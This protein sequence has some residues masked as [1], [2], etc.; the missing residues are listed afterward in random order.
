MWLRKWLIFLLLLPFGSVQAHNYQAR[1]DVAEW[2][3]EPGPMSCRL[4][5]SVP[6]YG[7]AVFETKAGQRQSFYVETYRPVLHEG[8]ARVTIKAPEWRTDAYPRSAGSATVH[9]GKRPIVLDENSSNML[10]AELEDGM[11]PSFRHTAWDSGRTLDADVSPV[12][13]PNAYAGYVACIAALFPASF[14]QLRNSTVHFEFDKYS[15]TP[16][17]RERLDLIASL[18]QLDNSVQQI[19]LD[20]HTDGKGRK[21][22]NYELSRHRAESV[23]KYLESK[24][25]ATD[26]IKM[27][28]FGKTRPI[29]PNTTEA[30]RAKNRRVYVQL[31]QG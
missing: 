20:G 1:V 23:K 14:D 10:L 21:W 2:H 13:F 8:I 15:L 11:Q 26:M 27:R 7:D 5:Q 24:G 6:N 29:K 3:L 4:W 16:A 12:N 25:V 17:A 31:V 30:N 9:T 18:I 28:Y 19:V 22:Y